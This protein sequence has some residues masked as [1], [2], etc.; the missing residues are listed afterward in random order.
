MNLEDLLNEDPSD[1]MVNSVQTLSE[2]I[3]QRR[4]Q[5]LVPLL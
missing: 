2:K 3:K 4:T 1:P 5:M